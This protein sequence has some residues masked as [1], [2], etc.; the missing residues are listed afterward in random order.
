MTKNG[1]SLSKESRAKWAEAHPLLQSV[2]DTA[3]TLTEVDFKVGEV[4][5]TKTR[6][7][8]LLATGKSKTLKS[9]HLINPANGK[10]Y[11]CDLYAIVNGRITW[12]NKY[13]YKICDAMIKA[14]K[15]HNVH[16]IWGGNWNIDLLSTSLKGE[17]LHK[18]YKGTL[19][20]LVHF[21]LSRKAYGEY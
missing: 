15:A 18:L 11:A 13:Y 19:H 7:A 20:D 2:I 16:I 8:M 12:E 6:Q 10:A 3:I 17:E 5:R 4:A 9:R 21:E 14:A 1:F